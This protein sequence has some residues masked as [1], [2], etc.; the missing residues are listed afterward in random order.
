M[1]EWV[2]SWWTNSSEEPSGGEKDKSLQVAA[3][4]IGQE[5]YAAL[6]T[7]K[8]LSAKTQILSFSFHRSS[9]GSFW[10]S[11]LGCRSRCTHVDVFAGVVVEQ[12]LP[13]RHDTSLLAAAVLCQH[14]AQVRGAGGL[15][16]P[17][18]ERRARWEDGTGWLPAL[19]RAHWWRWLSLDLEGLEVQGRKMKTPKNKWERARERE[20]NI[21][22]VLQHQP[23]SDES[24]GRNPVETGFGKLRIAHLCLIIKGIIRSPT[25]CTT[26]EWGFISALLTVPVTCS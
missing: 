1:R 8:G 3:Q 20:Q 22:K 5:H 18:W 6:K 7:S 4:G 15:T 9:P 21:F 17:S 24:A 23:M 10:V 19:R 25:C 26:D 14:P 16:N 13:Q 12:W 2:H 11:S